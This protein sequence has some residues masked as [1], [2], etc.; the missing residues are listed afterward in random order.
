MSDFEAIQQIVLDGITSGA[1]CAWRLLSV[2]LW[3]GV[4]IYGYLIAAT[5]GAICINGLLV[6]HSSNIDPVKTSNRIM[7]KRKMN[8]LIDEHMDS[9]NS[10]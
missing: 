1:S 7:A 8:K 9:N 3:F 6:N 10:E 5:L 2:P 4:P